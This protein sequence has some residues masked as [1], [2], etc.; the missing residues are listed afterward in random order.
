MTLKEMREKLGALGRELEPL[1]RKL[2]DGTLTDDESARVD[3]LLDDI[4]DL[5]PK[6]E[7]AVQVEEAS[8]RAS[9]LTAQPNGRRVSGEAPA[10]GADEQ[11]KRDLRSPLRRFIES[12]AYQR[13]IRSGTSRPIT[14]DQP[15]VVGSFHKRATLDFPE[16][17]GPDEMRALIYSGTGSA[18]ML[19]ADVFP[20]IYRGRERDLRMRDV[21][22][23]ARTNGDTVTVLQESGFTNAA[24]ETAES[25]AVD[26]TGLTGGVKPESALTFTEV[27][28]PVRT[29][30]HWI[31]VTR[32]MLADLPFMES[33]IEERLRVGLERRE[34]AQIINGNGTPPNLTGL[35]NT[36]N[37]QTL[38]DTYFA[39]APV[40]NAGTDV[41]N[42]NRILRAKT[43]I[44]LSTLGGAQ[45]T[46]VTL[47]P[48]DHETMLTVGNANDDYYGPG[49]FSGAAI[50]NLWGLSVVESENITAG[51][52]L[53]GD[54]LMAAVVDRMDATIYT[55]DS[56]SDFFIRNIL[57]ILAEERIALPVFRPEA[58]AAVDLV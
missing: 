52:A 47:N 17:I 56:H 3:S 28:F 22:A 13:E 20:T 46:F 9:T 54:G 45:A 4:N 35:L 39:G 50:T 24:A 55:T 32:Q 33:Y 10:E 38:D 36:S 19:L 18:S 11:E 29:I 57:V 49:P 42:F 12:D 16:G 5:G 43:N 8:K 2:Q 25:S 53:V 14:R 34:D 40:E 58:F 23:N 51:T 7:R 48:A 1:T 30:A 37:I 26:G 41:E 6:I 44:R 21:L 15:T 31:P 27:S